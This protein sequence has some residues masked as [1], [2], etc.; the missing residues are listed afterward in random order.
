MFTSVLLP[1]SPNFAE[2]GISPIPTL[3][4]TISIALFMFFTSFYIMSNINLPACDFVSEIVN[5]L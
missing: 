5:A 2:S 4:R 1:A 3:S